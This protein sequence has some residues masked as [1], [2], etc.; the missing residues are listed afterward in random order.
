LLSNSEV[1]P[2]NQVDLSEDKAGEAYKDVGRATVNIDAKADSKAKGTQVRNYS[3]YF[4]AKEAKQGR[5]T[6]ITTDTYDV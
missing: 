4:A 5:E 1:I 3:G 6:Q 2:S